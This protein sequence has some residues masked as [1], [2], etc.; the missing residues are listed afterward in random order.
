MERDRS[1]CALQSESKILHSLSP[2]LPTHAAMPSGRDKLG[3]ILLLVSLRLY[4][5]NFRL[6][7]A[8]IYIIQYKSCLIS[9]Y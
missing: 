4:A 9:N 3:S 5:S 7:P 6:V 8:Y 1:K 2:L